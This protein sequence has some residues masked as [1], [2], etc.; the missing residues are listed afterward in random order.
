MVSH[1]PLQRETDEY[2]FNNYHSSKTYIFFIVAT[3]C[4]HIDGLNVVY[5]KV[6][7]LIIEYSVFI[8]DFPLGFL[9]CDECCYSVVKKTS[10]NN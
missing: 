8:L 7:S 1:L 6:E 5:M 4:T 10:L 3:F 9:K 2:Y